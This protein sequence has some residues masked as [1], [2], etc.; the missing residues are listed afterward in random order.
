M[1][2][3]TRS[4]VH[5]YAFILEDLVKKKG[6]DRKQVYTQQEYR[7]DTSIAKLLALKTPE[8][9]IKIREQTFWIIEAKNE[10]KKVDLALKEAKE[11]YADK[12]NKDSLLKAIFVTGIAGND[13]EG[14]IAKS[15]YYKNGH[16][17]TIKENDIDV[18]GLLSK[19][20]VE[21]I[22][23]TNNQNIKEVEIT[24]QEFLKAA[25]EINGI[26]HE[27][28]INKDS[29]AKVMSAILLALSEGTDISLDQEPMLLINAINARVDLVLKKH[30]KSSFASFIKLDLPS[31]EDNHTKYKRA[32]VQ[33]IKEL[34]GLNIRSAMQSGKDVLG[35]FYEVFLKYGNGAKEI[36]IVLTPRH[37]TK[38]AAEV[39]DI[40]PND[41]VLDITC[42]T[43]GFLVAAFDEVRKKA[44]PSEFELF[45]NHGLYGIESQDPVV[46]LA[47][48][49]MIFRGDGKNNIIEGDCFAKWL[50]A[51]KKDLP[52]KKEISCAE[53]LDKDIK[54]RIPPITK[55]L[56]NPPFP[57]KKADKKEYLFIEHALKQMQNEGL[58]FSVLPYS[59]MIKG[60]AYKSWRQ[61]LLAENTVLSVITFPEDL[62]YPVGVHT[63]GIIIEKGKPHSKSEEVLWI[64]A[65]HDGRWKKKG[66]RLEHPKAQN[67]Y[68]QITPIIKSFLIERN[69]DVPNIPAF[70]KLS[71]IDFT[72]EDLELVPEAYLDEPSITQNE[73]EEKI[74]QI[75]RENI[76]FMIKYENRINID[77]TR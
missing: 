13:E 37:I 77:E 65:I 14:F 69:K 46:S 47:L 15:E 25:E 33:T 3:T 39:L 67:D 31:S 63:L 36:G 57:K 60:G 6:W 49:N 71:P 58:L 23:K 64:R 70:Q 53:Y 29:R 68:I 7:K 10:R 20:Q 41:L 74:D 45:K 17:E 30:K 62:F 1:A 48:V 61:R 16:W 75:I 40:Q 54:N 55:V 66:K 59:C 26:L 11:D 12:I 21:S 8:N 28:G 43:G 2:K 18:T 44:S 76:A 42:G 35:R 27:G 34:L 22:L 32:I 56:M 9:I 73:M 38:F 5:A 24:D 51:T 19:A 4:E 72:D 50:N 52:N